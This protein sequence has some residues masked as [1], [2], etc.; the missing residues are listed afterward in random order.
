[1]ERGEDAALAAVVPPGGARE[2]GGEIAPGELVRILVPEP[3]PYRV[4][5]RQ[6]GGQQGLG[7]RIAGAGLG[8]EQGR[9][10]QQPTR[11]PGHERVELPGAV[12]VFGT[13]SA[14][15]VSHVLI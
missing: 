9:G 11:R 6:G 1:M 7:V 8:G 14:P 12:G 2:A 10:V 13:V 5:V 4:G 15:L 3:V